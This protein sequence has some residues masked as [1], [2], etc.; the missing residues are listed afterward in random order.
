MSRFD[1]QP[2][3]EKSMDPIVGF[4]SIDGSPE[5]QL[6][7]RG[8]F[9]LMFAPDDSPAGAMKPHYCADPDEL[10]N[11]LGEL[12][13]TACVIAENVEKLQQFGCA[14]A[15]LSL[16]SRQRKIPPEATTDAMPLFIKAMPA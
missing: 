3:V 8:E 14:T 5:V 1:P 6:S 12:G 11:F 10:K 4:L 15:R 16:R 2:V 7:G 13:L 9:A